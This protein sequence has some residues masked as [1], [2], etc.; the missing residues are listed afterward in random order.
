MTIISVLTGNF[1][2]QQEDSS[3]H[4]GYTLVSPTVF[5]IF[6]GGNRDPSGRALRMTAQKRLYP[7]IDYSAK[8]ELPPDEQP[9]SNHLSCLPGGF[10]FI[11]STFPVILAAFHSS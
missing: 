6:P 8:K 7:E 1:P 3:L 9:S 5:Q 4:R 10:S 11:P 2:V